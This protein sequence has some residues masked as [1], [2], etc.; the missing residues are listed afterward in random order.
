MSESLEESRRRYA[1]L[2]STERVERMVTEIM[3]GWSKSRSLAI[4]NAEDSA[5]WDRLARAFASPEAEGKK[6][7]YGYRDPF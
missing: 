4:T 2:D 5:A 1:E 3:L 6:F 7:D